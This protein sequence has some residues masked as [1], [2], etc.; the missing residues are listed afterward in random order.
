MD[1]SGSPHEEPEA[2]NIQVV[3]SA[4]DSFNLLSRPRF[5][6][7]PSHVSLRWDPIDLAEPQRPL[8]SA[9]YLLL[10]RKHACAL[11]PAKAAQALLG[12]STVPCP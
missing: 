11:V 1:L 2:I 4:F 5:P 7:Q 6:T 3:S 12:S 8:I 10:D 9:V